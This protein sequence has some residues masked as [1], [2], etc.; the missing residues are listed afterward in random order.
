MFRFRIRC[1]IT[2]LFFLLAAT[3]SSAQRLVFTH[4]AGSNGG[5]GYDDGTGTAA[6]FSFANSVAVDSSGNVYVADTNN[7]TIRKISPSG[8]VTTLAGIAGAEGSLD[9]TGSAARFNRPQ[10][11]AV[12]GAGTAY[13]ADTNNSVIRKI[14]PAGAVTTLAGTAGS[15]GSSDGTGAAARFD[16]PQ[17]VAVDRDGNV[18]VADTENITIRKITPSGV[19]T[20]LAGRS[21]SVGITDGPGSEALFDTPGGIAVDGSG[22]IYVADTENSTVRKITPAGVVSTLAGKGRSSGTAD[23]TGSA[24]RF[25]GLAGVAVDSAG[26]V[27]VAD[28]FNSTIRKITPDG[29][30]TTLAGSAGVTGA[31]DAT[32]SAARFTFPSGVA[33]DSSGNV[34]VADL[35][36]SAVRNITPAGAV[37]TFAGA[38]PAPGATD[39]NG[40]AARFNAPRGVALDSAG[41]I[42]V[43]DMV[44]STI[45]KITPGGAVSTLA[46]SAGAMGSTDGTGAAARFAAPRG[47]AVDVAGNVYVADTANHTIRKITPGGVVTTLAGAA[48]VSGSA[49]GTGSTAQFNNPYDVAVDSSG[50]IYVADTRNDTIRK[51]TSAGAVT[52]LAGDARFSGDDDGTGAD[53]RFDQPNGIAVDL[54]GN[55]YVADT[56]NHIIRKVTPSGVVTTLAG[57]GGQDGSRD[58]DGADARFWSPRGVAV[59]A[60]GNVY[61]A[62]SDN[63]TIRKITPTGTVTTVAGLAETDGS[64]DGI[65]SSARFYSPSDVAVDAAGH[66]YVADMLNHAIRV[67]SPAIAD[68]ATIDSNVVKIGTVRHLDTSPQTATSWQWMIIRRPAGST[69]VLSSSSI[70]NPT[71]V[72]DAADLYQF[73]VVASNASGTSITVVSLGQYPIRRRAVAH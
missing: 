48:G 44:N 56:E 24:A 23:G 60:A 41:N 34:Y 28:T 42:Y 55:I 63:S 7:S 39:G 20:T 53:A 3:T 22:N 46:G 57:Q 8:V 40:T 69:A 11:I 36:N 25:D 19:V 12:D 17:G 45:R 54:S 64:I 61:V 16:Y 13:V 52:T 10:G 62:D 51:I 47:L 38:A 68:T 9:G 59:D 5:G 15:S 30:V 50:N 67:G 72:P 73:R 37:T 21:F 18:Y 58:G 35:I 32:G 4:F 6:R 14:T 27:Y 49:D 33:V 26:N 43:A 31:A 66:I 70:R 1:I 2:I 65:G 29:V 71:F